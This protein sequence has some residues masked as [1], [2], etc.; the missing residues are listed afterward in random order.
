MM[1]RSGKTS[2]VQEVESALLPCMDYLH[3]DVVD[4]ELKAAC[5]YEY[6]RES[7]HLC[8][9]A[10]F[11]GKEKHS[12]K[13]FEK[14]GLIWQCP[15]FPRKSWNELSQQERSN[16]LQGFRWGKIR[17]LLV[18]DLWTLKVTGIF[19]QL[20]TMVAAAVSNKARKSRQKVY[21]I[22]EDR[23]KVV[24]LH[25]LFTLDLGKT[26]KQLLQEF[27]EWLDLPENKARLNAHQQN[28]TG[29][30]GVFKDR[31]KDLAA[32]RLYRELGCKRAL[33]FAEEHRKRDKHGKPKPFH[34]AR[35]EQSK[36][37]MPL[38]KAPLYSEYNEESG[39]RKAKARALA[40][41][42][43]LIPWALGKSDD[44][45]RIRNEVANFFGTARREP[46]RFLRSSS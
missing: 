3:G 37:K 21:P 31:L 33:A 1:R 44:P 39:F 32:C 19:D 27:K 43:E 29:K 34:D 30:T 2:D 6:K 28:P 11:W 40:Y 26:R 20:E 38:N 7:A 4:N 15:S 36:A 13:E 24:W 41:E 14:K 46:G 22:I 16:V 23:Y 18:V 9:M 8:E 5:Y 25:V 42:K 10:R 12:Y 35:K 45:E 17:P